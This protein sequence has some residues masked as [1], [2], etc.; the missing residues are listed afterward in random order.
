MIDDK[1]PNVTPELDGA[2][3]GT[4]AQV[5]PDGDGPDAT[6]AGA[7]PAGP[8]R[9]HK[10]E[11]TPAKRGRGR[12]PGSRSHKAKPAPEPEAP[13]LDD[14]KGMIA[15]ALTVSAQA[16]GPHWSEPAEAFDARVDRLAAAWHPV[17]LRYPNAVN[18]DVLLWS[19]AVGATVRELAPLVRQSM[20]ERR[21]LF[22]KVR[23]WLD[24]R[25][26]RK[27]SGR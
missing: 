8:E 12:P 20:A 18:P 11:P 19:V 26:A 14:T 13:S 5:R 10:A 22:G 23:A 6:T 24:R 9:E 21:G 3:P 25:R 16:F 7:G 1:A 15:A 2:G 27:H 17:R 4:P